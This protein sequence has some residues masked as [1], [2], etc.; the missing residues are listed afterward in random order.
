M[1]SFFAIIFIAISL[2]L[3]FIAV[4]LKYATPSTTLDITNATKGMYFALVLAF[5][6]L[7]ALISFCYKSICEKIENINKE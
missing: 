3:L 1:K 2:G 7:A 5:F 6:G 4:A